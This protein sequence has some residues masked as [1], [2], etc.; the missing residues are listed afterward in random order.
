MISP[1]LSALGLCED[2]R[3]SVLHL[4]RVSPS[5]PLKTKVHFLCVAAE[6]SLGL[7][8]KE[9]PHDSDSAGELER[10]LDLDYSR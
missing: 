9:C 5:V 2:L 4:H 8:C 1:F 7:V 3:G 6:S 10:E